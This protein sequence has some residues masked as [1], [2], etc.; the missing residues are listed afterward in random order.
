MPNRTTFPAAQPD[1]G[2]S[3]SSPYSFRPS[4][5]VCPSIVIST[6]MTVLALTASRIIL[7][8]SSRQ[9]QQTNQLVSSLRFG[10]ITNAI[11]TIISA[12]HRQ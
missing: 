2:M 5:L 4:P 6:L 11:V 3:T 1:Q 9:H 10:L 8:I 7:D 12:H